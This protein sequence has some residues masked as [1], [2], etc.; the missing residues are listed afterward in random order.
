MVGILLAIAC[1]ERPTSS[2]DDLWL[3]TQSTTYAYNSGA[4][5][6]ATAINAA[7][8][9]STPV[10]KR[11]LVATIVQRRRDVEREQMRGKRR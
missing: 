2:T 8:A 4:A 5:A 10:E 1:S 6:L 11:R 7:K 3:L 9:P